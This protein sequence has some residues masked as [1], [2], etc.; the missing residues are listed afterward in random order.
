MARL[1]HDG[2]GAAWSPR[3]HD[4]SNFMR[5]RFLPLALLSA[6]LLAGCSNEAPDDQALKRQVDQSLKQAEDVNAMVQDAAAKQRQ[7]IDEQSK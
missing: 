3:S 2:A 5:H 6:A 1:W 4:R 7:A